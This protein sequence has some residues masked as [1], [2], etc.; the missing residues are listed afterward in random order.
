[1]LIVN[2]ERNRY[3]KSHPNQTHAELVSPSQALREG[4]LQKLW[5]EYASHSSGETEADVI[6]KEEAGNL[7]V[8]RVEGP[9]PIEDLTLDIAYSC[10]FKTTDGLREAW[11][12]RHPRSYSVKIV[13]FVLGDW[14][15]RDKYLAWSGRRA[16]ADEHGYTMSSRKA[17]DRDAPVPDE[18]VEG[19]AADNLQKDTARRAQ[20]SSALASASAEERLRRLWEYLLHVRTTKGEEAFRAVYGSIRQHVRV[21][22]QRARRSEARLKAKGKSGQV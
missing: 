2:V 17:M 14:R 6:K 13:W 4:S 9:V 21:M 3:L 11:L 22:E 16:G 15:D 20:T 7:T 18:I 10:G 12:L 19:Y 5:K 8:V 1:M